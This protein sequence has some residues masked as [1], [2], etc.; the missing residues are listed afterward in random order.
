MLTLKYYQLINL[1][2]YLSLSFFSLV[3]LQACANTEQL[4][5]SN[6]QTQLKYPQQ[7]ELVIFVE[8]DISNNPLLGTRLTYQSKLYDF[9]IFNVQIYPIRQLNWQ[10]QSDVLMDEMR[11]A[12][13]ELDS[14][15]EQQHYQS[16][17][18]EDVAQINLKV[19]EQTVTS[20][21]GKTVIHLH[22]E[23][24]MHSYIYIL[25]QQDKI[26]RINCNMKFAEQLP[27]PD[28]YIESILA[29][30][31]V[32]KESRYMSDLR[33]SVTIKN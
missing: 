17:D 31:T 5:V 6:Y 26:I 8:Q 18:L 13:K 7:T 16:R 32:P 1:A 23:L 30:L 22:D 33:K 11:L 20:V 12:Y 9:D 25:I 2:T 3:G 29:E 21:R 19:N 15:I 4:A 14:Q 24:Y 28:D 27:P 10:T